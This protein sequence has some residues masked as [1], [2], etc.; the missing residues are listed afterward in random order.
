[1]KERVAKCLVIIVFLAVLGACGTSGG[2]GGSGGGSSPDPGLGTVSGMSP[3]DNSTT[4]DS[5]AIL[6]W[7]AVAGATGYEVQ[8]ANTEA[9]VSA[10]SIT[11]VDSPG[12]ELTNTSSRFWFWRVRAVD[13]TRFGAWSSIASLSLR[14]NSVTLDAVGPALGAAVGDTTPE[15]VWTAV[16]GAA[17]YELQMD[18]AALASDTAPIPATANETS[19]VPDAPLLDEAVT[20][21]WRARA[22]DGVGNPTDWTGGTFTF[23]WGSTGPADGIRFVDELAYLRDSVNNNTPGFAA[24]SYRLGADIDLSGI[25]W[26]P[27]GTPSAPFTG[28]FDGAGYTISG[29]TIND[30]TAD[31]RGLFGDVDGGTITTVRLSNVQITARGN[32]GG[33]AG[34]VRSGA[35]VTESHIIG[36]SDEPSTISGSNRNVG[37]L[38]GQVLDGGTIVERS[39][40]SANVSNTSNAHTTG[41]GTGGLVGYV[42]GGTISDSHA[43][44][45]VSGPHLVGGLAGIISGNSAAAS[46]SYATGAV[47][48][49]HAFGTA[50]G[51]VGSVQV[52]SSVSASYASGDVSGNRVGGLVGLV[53]TSGSIED[54]YATGEVSG[55]ATNTNFPSFV[56]GLV[57]DIIGGTVSRSYAIGRVSGPDTTGGLTGRS[58]GGAIT[59]NS[60]YDTSTTGQSASASGDGKTTSEMRQ[61][62]TFTG[63]NFSTVWAIDSAT[64]GGYPYLR[65]IP[66]E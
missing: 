20:Y 63:W 7:N 39:S 21:H 46:Q 24:G 22:V 6:R 17:R 48:S 29:L 5:S 59:N 16:P 18:T 11:A 65:A 58:I 45:T 32:V 55:V 33:L 52:S 50:G 56:G 1:M 15:F 36:T 54:S 40:S 41:Q 47:S 2:G 13:D 38:V 44:G 8:L 34:R 9:E 3:A 43:S 64:N 37:G 23:V 19:Y 35:Q 25:G 66:P 12:L 28:T 60:F 53:S 14:W 30:N 31:Y 42:D 10:A 57:A 27:I 49:T 26:T 51:L 61:Q 62:A 4:N